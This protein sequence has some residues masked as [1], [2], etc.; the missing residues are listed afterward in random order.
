MGASKDKVFSRNPDRPAARG[1]TGL[2]NLPRRI[3]R[4]APPGSGGSGKDRVGGPDTCLHRVRE[5]QQE[6]APISLPGRPASRLPPARLARFVP[7]DP[8]PE[9]SKRN[10]RS[11][12]APPYQP[13]NRGQKAGVSPVADST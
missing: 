11:R 7:A 3:S 2:V 8:P 12:A 10:D 13:P 6:K 1:P 5:D 9:A 4:A